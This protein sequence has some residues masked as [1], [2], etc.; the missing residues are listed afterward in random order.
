MGSN[1]VADDNDLD[2]SAQLACE[3][4]QAAAS[5]R[6]VVWMRSDDHDAASPED[7]IQ[8]GYG[9]CVGACE[10]FVESQRPGH[11]S[12]TGLSGASRNA[13]ASQSPLPPARRAMC[14]AFVIRRGGISRH[15]D[16]PVVA[17]LD[18][19]APVRLC[20]WS[21]SAD[22]T[23]WAGLAIAAISITPSGHA[24]RGKP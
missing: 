23:D 9:E 15:R 3:R 18:A 8:I 16:G 14:P 17:S 6:L 12:L 13:A 7:L 21:V 10:E 5:E 1:A 20:V 22:E 2:V 24:P 4:D 11:W 19:A